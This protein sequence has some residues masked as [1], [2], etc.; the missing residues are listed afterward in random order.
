MTY[1]LLFSDIALKFEDFLI[2]KH[3]G[4]VQYKDF[5]IKIKSDLYIPW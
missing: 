5:C 3:H 4:S 2:E 1:I